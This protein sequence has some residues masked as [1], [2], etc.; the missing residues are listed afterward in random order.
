[1][2]FQCSLPGIADTRRTN[3]GSQPTIPQGES[4]SYAKDQLGVK[5]GET[6]LL[7]VPWNKEEDTIQI[8]FSAPITNT[9]KRELLGKIAEIYDP[10]GL[11]SLITLK[12]KILYREVCETRIPW[13]QKLLQDLEISWQTWETN[14]DRGTK[15]P[16]PAPRS[17]HQHQHPRLW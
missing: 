10:L 2:A 15:K 13:D 8:T 7:S 4:H 12:G 5:Q 3:N 9:T 16:C 14:L 17:D 1:M 11:A 6:K